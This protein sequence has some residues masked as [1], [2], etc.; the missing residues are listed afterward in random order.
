M[1][2]AQVFPFS[3]AKFLRTPFFIE[4]PR[5]LLLKI[6]EYKV[7]YDQQIAEAQDYI[8]WNARRGKDLSEKTPTIQR[9]I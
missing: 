1:T 6:E 7:I 5:W 4:H 3:F 2:L 9:Q 8:I